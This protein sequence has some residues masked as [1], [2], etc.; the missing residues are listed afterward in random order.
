[1]TQKK[2]LL[3]QYLEKQKYM[4]SQ[5][6]SDGFDMKIDS[7][8][9]PESNHSDHD[10]HT[11]S[12][13]EI[14][15]EY[16]RSSRKKT[17]QYSTEQYYHIGMIQSTMYVSR[18]ELDHIRRKLN[19][20]NGKELKSSDNKRIK[21]LKLLEAHERDIFIKHQEQLEILMPEQ[22]YLKFMRKILKNG[23]VRI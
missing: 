1:M 3:F 21:K 4:D 7:Y 10:D 19:K 6:Q 23:R 15:V 22:A 16:P 5:V 17:I 2:R 18:G 13:G 14:M 11:S 9:N 12:N 20:F 8:P